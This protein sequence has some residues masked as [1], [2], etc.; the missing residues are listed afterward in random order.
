L[1]ASV[2]NAFHYLGLC[3]FLCAAGGSDCSLTAKGIAA[4]CQDMGVTAE[5]IE[6][7]SSELFVPERRGDDSRA[8]FKDIP[9]ISRIF[10]KSPESSN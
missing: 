9:L 1:R 3:I 10:P 6:Q 5:A 8:A 7:R 4:S 2:A